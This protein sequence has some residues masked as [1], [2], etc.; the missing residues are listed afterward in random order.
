MEIKRAENSSGNNE[1][2]DY[3]PHF[4]AKDLRLGFPSVCIMVFSHFKICRSGG[5]SMRLT[6]G[7]YK[8]HGKSLVFIL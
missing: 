1:K 5:A 4:A 3:Y 7:H 2:S 6:L 8:N